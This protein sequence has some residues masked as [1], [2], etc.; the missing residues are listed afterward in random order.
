MRSCR[1][2]AHEN[3]D[4]LAFCSRCGRKLPRTDGALA[5]IMR[6][7]GGSDPAGYSRTVL[8]TPGPATTTGRATVAS[9]RN[10]SG[11]QAAVAEASAFAPPSRSRVRWLGESVGYIYVYLRGKLDAGERRRRLSEERT[12]AEALLAG[13]LNELGQAVLREGV[14]HP[15]LTGL[16]EEIGRAHA[17]RETAAA[18]TATSESLQQAE[19]VRLA[20]QQTAAEAE[21]TA[22]DSASREAEQ[23]LRAATADRRTTGSRLARVTDERARIAREANQSGPIADVRLAQLDHEDAGLATEQRALEEQSKRLDQQ[24]ADLRARAATLRDAATGAKAKLDQTVGE[25]RQAASAMAA[26]IAGRQ[27][28]RAAAEREIADLTAQIGRVAFEVRPPHA[29]LL[30]GYQNIDRLNQTIAERTAQLAAIEQARGHYDHRKLLA[31]VG[32]LTC[33]LGAISAALWKL[34]K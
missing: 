9:G 1:H 23:I 3:A 17:R 22:A 25:R 16:L 13:A 12:G 24:L 27:R 6:P 21:W 30:S 8:A 33:M 5:A 32:V 31:G 20:G 7:L 19:A 4:H 18:D 28:D 15:E 34:L 14:Q 10:L 26:S 29:T 2:C 11:R